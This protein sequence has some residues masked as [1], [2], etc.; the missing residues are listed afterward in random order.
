MDLKTLAEATKK[1]QAEK[2]KENFMVIH[3]EAK[4]VLPHKDGLAF[5]AALAQ[6]E[7]LNDGYYDT[8][9]GIHELDKDTIRATMLSRQEYERHKMAALLG[10]TV[11]DIRNAQKGEAPPTNT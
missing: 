2:P 6:A 4:L 11:D 8:P 3:L 7:K 9:K 10:V 5:M 1:V